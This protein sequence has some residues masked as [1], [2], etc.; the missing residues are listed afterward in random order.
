MQ[1]IMP[2]WWNFNSSIPQEK[3]EIAKSLSKCLDEVKDWMNSCHLKMNSDKTGVI[4][5]GSWQQIKKCRLTALEV[6]GESKLYSESIKYLGVCIA[7]NLH[8][9]NH[10]VSKC[11]TAMCNLFKIVNI[12]NFLTTEACHT[13]ILATVISHLDY[14][15]AIMVGLLEKIMQS[16][17][18]FRIWLQ[19]LC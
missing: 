7:S 4:L 18:M 13:A 12:R 5:F 1:M 17:S 2:L 11:R 9:H 19:K 8:L 14:V 15:N 3:V 16:C 6:C 10:I